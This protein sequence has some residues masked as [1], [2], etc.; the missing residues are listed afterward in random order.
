M[1]PPRVSFFAP[2]AI[3][4]EPEHL[5]IPTSVILKEPKRPKDLHPIYAE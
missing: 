4:R 2:V 5:V 1:P 3:L